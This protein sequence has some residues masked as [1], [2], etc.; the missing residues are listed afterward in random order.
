MKTKPSLVRA[1]R[2]FALIVLLAGL[3]VW[4]RSGARLGW[5]QTSVVTL[6]HDEITGIEF[7]VRHNAFVAGIEVPLLAVAAAI[8][9]VGLSLLA[10]RRLAPVKA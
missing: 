10:Q 8:G 9:A 6:Q 7:P 3:A 1:L 4:T 2:V 5:T